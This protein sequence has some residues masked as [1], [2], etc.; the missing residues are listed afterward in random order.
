M[1]LHLV[2]RPSPLDANSTKC[3]SAQAADSPHSPREEPPD[4]SNQTCLE[5]AASGKEQ[6]KCVSSCG[7]KD[8]QSHDEKSFSGKKLLCPH[9]DCGKVFGSLEQLYRHLKR[10]A[11]RKRDYTCSVCGAS[12]SVFSA[13][14][15]HKRS[16]HSSKV[17]TCE[18][19]GKA[20]TRTDRLKAHVK[21]SNLRVHVRVKHLN[22]RRF[23]CSEC[24][25]TF[26][27][28][29]VLRRHLSS[30]HGRRGPS[31]APPLS[32]SLSNQ[33]K[34]DSPRMQSADF[35][36]K[37]VKGG[38]PPS[39]NA[40]TG[41]CDAGGNEADFSFMASRA[42]GAASPTQAS[43]RLQQSAEEEAQSE[44]AVSLDSTEQQKPSPAKRFLVDA[45]SVNLVARAN[46]CN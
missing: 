28:K 37:Q 14:V 32:S 3:G 16:V 36:S 9:N 1:L 40:T 45:V 20:Y 33:G 42:N 38:P 21:K 34:S 25:M 11:Q 31:D 13:L 15:A 35:P 4:D 44:A 18:H 5:A 39:Q 24:H 23:S 2:A 26:A 19:C 46:A 27:Y 12:Y 41:E 10:A 8:D 7:V 22:E 43:S 6:E 30:V 29:S 17:H